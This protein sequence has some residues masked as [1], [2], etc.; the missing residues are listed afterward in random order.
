MFAFDVFNPDVRI[1]AKPT[2]Q[3]FPVMEVETGLFGTLS[4]DGTH[5]YDSA[6]QVNR[7]TWYVSAP[8]NPDAWILPLVLRSIF[9]QDLPLM[10]AAG[11]FHL[12]SRFGDLSKKP[13]GSVSPQQVCLTQDSMRQP[14]LSSDKR[15]KNSLM[16][17]V[18]GYAALS[19]HPRSKNR[20]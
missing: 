4:V 12:T 11:G 20:F 1:L 16:L 6:T 17:R 2:G 14:Q 13:F 18:F 19:H 9:P 3:R 7:A 8:G 15:D 10:L 5:D